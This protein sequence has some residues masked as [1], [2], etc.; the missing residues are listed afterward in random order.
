MFME[1]VTFLALAAPP[2][3]GE[4]GAGQGA[5]MMNFLFIGMMVLVFYLLIWRPNAQRQKKHKQ[6]LA[7]LKKGDRIVTNGG[8][9]ATVLNVKE[10][11]LVCS[12]AD[13]VK[14]EIARNAV[15]GVVES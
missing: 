6:M 7:D 5:M 8:L 2:R 4:A 11:R 10:D 14:V 15:S 13:G 9:F 3:E 12:I 1:F